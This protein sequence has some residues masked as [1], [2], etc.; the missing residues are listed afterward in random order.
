MR[1]GRGNGNNFFNNLP[2]QPQTQYRQ[3]RN[4]LRM[5]TRR[6]TAFNDQVNQFYEQQDRLREENARLRQQNRDYRRQNRDY[7]RQNRQLQNQIEATNQQFPWYNNDFWEQNMNMFDVPVDNNLPQQ[8]PQANN[9]Y[10]DDQFDGDIFEYP[11]GTP[12]VFIDD[13]DWNNQIDFND[14]YNDG[15]NNYNY[16][17]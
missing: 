5:L 9:Q 12:F 15:Y 11:Q 14:Q 4:D 2:Q 7:R 3:N 16:F 8:L 1:R 6:E 13:N 10:G 17:L